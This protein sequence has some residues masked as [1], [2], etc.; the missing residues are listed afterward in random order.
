VYHAFFNGQCGVLRVNIHR[1]TKAPP[2]TK[3]FVW[4]VLLYRCWIGDM[5]LCHHMA[6][7]A[8]CG[9]YSQLDESINHLLLGCSYSMEVWSLLDGPGLHRLCP[10]GDDYLSCRKQVPRCLRKG[11][12]SMVVLV[13]WQLWSEPNA[14]MIFNNTTK[15]AAV[16]EC[17]IREDVRC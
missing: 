6:D 16:L 4:L 5:L 8:M 9:L 17:W 7:S 1:R 3:F 11:F 13:W 12:N 14:R 15:Q 2:N 10:S